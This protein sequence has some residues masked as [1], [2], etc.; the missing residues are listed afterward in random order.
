MASRGGTRWPR[1]RVPSRLR[2]ASPWPCAPPR[3][4]YRGPWLPLTSE[5]PARFGHSP[6]VGAMVSAV[7][8]RSSRLCGKPTVQPFAQSLVASCGTLDLGDDVHE[9]VRWWRDLHWD[10]P[11]YAQE[12]LRVRL[13][14]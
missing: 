4:L 12:L 5:E 1:V 8:T 6:P 14:L 3:A 11:A 13:D 10:G 7:I 2:R 9:E